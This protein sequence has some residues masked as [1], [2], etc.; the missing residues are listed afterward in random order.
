MTRSEFIRTAR[1]LGL[2]LAQ[3]AA[4]LAGLSRTTID[5]WSIQA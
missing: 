4:R 3:Y 5:L 2:P 1:S